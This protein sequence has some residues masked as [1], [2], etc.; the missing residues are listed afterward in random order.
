MGEAVII[1]HKWKCIFVH[2]P[3]T[4]GTSIETL[5][6]GCDWWEI[7]RQTKHIRASQAKAIYAK[8]WDSYVTFSVWRP[9]EDRLESFR[10]AFDHATAIEP[11]EWYL[12]EPLDYLLNF[13]DIAGEWAKL[14]RQLGAPL[15]LPHV[16]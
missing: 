3:R 12:D 10:K 7:E 5:L 4:A 8:W 15:E 6:V 1:S 11:N 2:M 16:P 14:A 9:Y 13:N